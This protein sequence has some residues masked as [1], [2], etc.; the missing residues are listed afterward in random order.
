MHAVVDWQGMQ[1]ASRAQMGCAPVCHPTDRSR[2]QQ[3]D[4]GG[5][6]G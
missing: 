4:E 6:A 3:D 5:K 1:P 2:D